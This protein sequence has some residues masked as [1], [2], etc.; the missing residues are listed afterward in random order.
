M[1]LSKGR[2]GDTHP[3]DLRTQ[4]SLHPGR[5]ESCRKQPFLPGEGKGHRGPL[6]VPTPTC[7]AT[8]SWGWGKGRTQGEEAE[9]RAGEQREAGAPAAED[10]TAAAPAAA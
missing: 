7:R 6:Q 9:D 10:V 2:V 3:R 1:E 8:G 5:E 4:A